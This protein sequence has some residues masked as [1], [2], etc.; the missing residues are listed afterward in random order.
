ML[1][2][3]QLRLPVEHTDTD[4]RH[5]VAEWLK[6]EPDMVLSLMVKQRAIDARKR[7]EVLFCYTIHIELVD[8]NEVLNREDKPA[9]VEIA[10]DERYLELDRI[11]QT[12]EARHAK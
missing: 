7:S 11:F 3:S 6:V 2:I 8:E 12:A 10:P 9:H 5:A 1:Q 4:L